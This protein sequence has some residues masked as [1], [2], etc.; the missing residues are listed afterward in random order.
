ML[1]SYK[2][3]NNNNNKTIV[4]NKLRENGFFTRFKQIR[5]LQFQSNLTRDPTGK[6]SCWAYGR[7]AFICSYD[8]VCTPKK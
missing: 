6:P 2:L 7:C 5:I 4:N 1:H 3:N 8:C